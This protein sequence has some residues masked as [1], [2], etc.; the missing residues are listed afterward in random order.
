[1]VATRACPMKRCSTASNKAS[2]SAAPWDR[3]TSGRNTVVTM[4]TPP[5]QTTTASTCRARAIAT[6]SMRRTRLLVARSPVA[7]ELDEKS[8]GAL[9]LDLMRLFRLDD[10]LAVGVQGDFR[11]RFE[12]PIGQSPLEYVDD[13]PHV[14]LRAVTTKQSGRRRVLVEDRRALVG[15]EAA[16]NI[17]SHS[18]SLRK[19]G[20]DLPAI[21]PEPLAL[22]QQGAVSDR[23]PEFE[24]LGDPMR[25][26]QE[27]RGRLGRTQLPGGRLEQCQPAVKVFGVDRQ[28]QMQLH[29]L[30]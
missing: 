9:R 26:L 8:D 11:Q 16:G 12:R 10:A 18:A 1:M 7:I 22:R 15:D 21:A 6:S 4:A 29:R 19:M 30:A 28:R 23:D 5:T 2:R 27:T 24:A 3:R 17:A 20:E 25:P 13:A 14:R